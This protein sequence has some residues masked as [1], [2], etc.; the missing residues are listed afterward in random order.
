MAALTISAPPTR[1]TSRTEYFLNRL[2]PVTTYAHSA[3]AGR[4]TRLQPRLANSGTK[5]PHQSYRVES[6]ISAFVGHGAA[7]ATAIGAHGPIWHG[8]CQRG[9]TVILSTDALHRS[10]AGKVVL[11]LFNAY[12]T[13]LLHRN[14]PSSAMS[15]LG[16]EEAPRLSAGGSDLCPEYPLF[17]AC[18]WGRS[19]TFS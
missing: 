3:S 2:R 17:P 5:L 7:L 18:S 10:P 16:H 8:A 14:V 13:G 11:R 4:T 15:G 9:R 19:R 12:R 6:R 1:A